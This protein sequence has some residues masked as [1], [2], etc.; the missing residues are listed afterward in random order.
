L[1]RAAPRVDA[2]QCVPKQGIAD[3]TTVNVPPSD[4]AERLTLLP[5]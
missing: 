4:W 3:G 1:A 2:K 5:P